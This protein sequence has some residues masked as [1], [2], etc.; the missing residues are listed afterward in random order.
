[1]TAITVEY[2]PVR[3]G[4]YQVFRR[5]FSGVRRAITVSRSGKVRLYYLRGRVRDGAWE[6]H[7]TLEDDPEFQREG[8]NDIIASGY[9]L[10]G[11]VDRLAKQARARK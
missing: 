1:M 11:T 5:C 8:L 4:Y 6:E 7:W 3:R 10:V 2:P 9:D